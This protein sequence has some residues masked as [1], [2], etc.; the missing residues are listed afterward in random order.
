MKLS[1]NIRDRGA[2]CFAKRDNG[3]SDDFPQRTGGTRPMFARLVAYA[4]EILNPSGVSTNRRDVDSGGCSARCSGNLTAC[5]IRNRPALGVLRVAVRTL[6]AGFV[7]FS[8]ICSAQTITYTMQG[9]A[10]G[11]LVLNGASV[12]FSNAAYNF[13]VV[14]DATTIIPDG[15]SDGG[16]YTSWTTHGAVSIDGVAGTFSNGVMVEVYHNGSASWIS[17]AQQVNTSSY[18]YF[19]TGYSGSLAAY[20]LK[21]PI[22]P[23]SLNSPA[24]NAFNPSVVTS[25]GSFTLTS[26]SSASFTASNVMPVSALLVDTGPGG[27]NFSSAPGLASGGANL[28]AANI[29]GNFQFLAGQFTLTNGAILDS[30]EAWMRVDTGG[31]LTVN[32]RSDNNGIPGGSVFSKTYTLGLQPIGWVPFSDYNVV[33]APGT[34]WLAFEPVADS[35]FSGF[36]AVM[37]VGAPYPLPNYAFFDNGNNGY[38]DFGGFGPQPGFGMR[39]SGTGSTF[40]PAPTFGT[41]TREFLSG[42]YIKTDPTRTVKDISLGDVGKVQTLQFLFDEF[43]GDHRAHA[44]ITKDGLSA[45][46]WSASNGWDSGGAARAVAFRTFINNTNVPLTFRV[47]AVLDGAFNDAPFGLPNGPAGVG[48]AIHVFDAGMF[49]AV[50]SASGVTVRQFLLGGSNNLDPGSAFDNLLSLFPG[51]VLGDGRTFASGG[52]NN[53]QPITL[54]VTTDFIVVRPRQLFTVIFDVS[55]FSQTTTFPDRTGAQTAD[56]INTLS[57]AANFF[58]DVNGNSATGIAPVSYS[59]LL[60]PPPTTLT[61]TPPTTSSSVGTSQTVTASA[62]TDGGLPA[63]DSVVRFI[64]TSGPNAGLIG[65][66]DTDANG[67]ATFTYTGTHG[68]GTD[69]IQAQIGG[70]QSNFVE[71]TWES[72]DTI[73]PTMTGS[74]N[75]PPKSNGWSNSDETVTLNAS[76]ELGGSG[77]KEIHYALSGAQTGSSIVSGSSAA[78]TV[79]MEGITTI[80][81]FSVDNAGNQ[82]VSKTLAIR[83]DKTPPSISCSIS[84]GLWHAVDVKV[85]CTAT[86][87]SSGL[88]N[89]SDA[90]FSLSTAVPPGTESATAVTGIHTVCDAAG[91]CASAGPVGGNMVDKKAP[92]ISIVTPTNT[93]YLLNQAV[94]AN[95]TCSDSG[96]GVATCTGA[97]SSGTRIDASSIGTKTFTA[98]AADKVGNSASP[99]S[100]SYSVKYGLCPLYDA[101]R[102]IQSGSTIPLKLQLCDAN[103]SDVSSSAVVLHATSLVRIATNASEVI[104][105]SGD[106]NPDNDFRFDSS[107]GPTGGYIFSLSTKGLTTGSYLLSFSAGGDPVAHT[108]A[109]QVR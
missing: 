83:L 23:L 3:D 90:N 1:F 61:L 6:L 49:N 19:L 73:P 66:G 75:P 97:V 69:R 50:I 38:L 35:G 7:L 42:R 91:N 51:A 102:S 25:F 67:K 2:L 82:G 109:F 85:A 86:D 76:D 55:T 20:D 59:P 12:Q 81:F 4:L 63:P 39:I 78:L 84:D 54:S 29:F 48:A 106:A 88:A 11:N 87:A 43:L 71:Q 37:P 105:S 9:T 28:L 40:A 57:P 80:T 16:F 92:T 31:S 96:S 89:S 21:S 64:V 53:G 18:F 100:V 15:S 70:L 60:P 8:G 65:A 79:S 74:L 93:S 77:V 58:T 72:A 30:V 46:S 62:T 27:T 33:L 108:L 5:A 56:F 24:P 26:V 17:L 107:L 44:T 13:S 99:Q 32:L 45:G 104:Q 52:Q 10:S 22:G 98:N 47:N 95:Y 14:T 36:S 41:V 101:G 94:T 68:V 34:Y 103:N